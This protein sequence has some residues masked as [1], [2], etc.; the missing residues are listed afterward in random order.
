MHAHSLVMPVCTHCSV[1]YVV[2]CDVCVCVCVGVCVRA[3]V[4]VCVCCMRA[5]TCV[6][7]RACML[8]DTCTYVQMY[9]YT[10][11]CKNAYITVRRQMINQRYTH[12]H[13]YLLKVF[14]SFTLLVDQFGMF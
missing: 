11:G 1:I 2:Y 6:S 3:C 7:V 9:A 5:C 4:C 10:H 13:R 12:I 14:D 8:Y